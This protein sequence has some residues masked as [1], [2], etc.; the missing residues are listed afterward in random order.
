MSHFLATHAAE[1]GREAP[2]LSDAEAEFLMMYKW[3]GN[4]RELENLAKRIVLLGDSARAIQEL[5]QMPKVESGRREEP[6]SLS[7]KAAAR[8][9]SRKAERDMITKA[10]ELTHWNRKRAAE[11]LQISYNSLLYK[12]RQTGLEEE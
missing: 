2:V 9:A 11:H 6:G 8:T 1:L 5:Q 12:I 3:P 10:L 4:V 7:L